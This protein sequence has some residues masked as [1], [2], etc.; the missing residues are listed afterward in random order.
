MQK[1]TPGA[2]HWRK[3][4][5]NKILTGPSLIAVCPSCPEC[6]SSLVEEKVGCDEV[7]KDH[8]RRHIRQQVELKLF[9]QPLFWQFLL[10]LLDFAAL[11]M[12]YEFTAAYP[13]GWIGPRDCPVI[14]RGDG[15]RRLHHIG[16][17]WGMSSCAWAQA[18]QRH[19]CQDSSAFQ[20]LS[21]ILTLTS[22]VQRLCGLTG[23][24]RTYHP[25]DLVLSGMCSVGVL[26]SH[27]VWDVLPR[28]PLP[29]FQKKSS[30]H[31]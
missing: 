3:K 15:H 2:T 20:V 16:W 26:L 7:I 27:W 17:H 30:L 18:D 22:C 19:F 1:I 14:L 5:R 25:R 28:P 31:F 24:D 29:V 4:G 23:S 6:S 13:T 8:I 21:P 12:M 9:W 11:M 10:L